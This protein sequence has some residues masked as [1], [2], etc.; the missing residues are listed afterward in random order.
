MEDSK[1]KLINNCEINFVIIVTALQ[2]RNTFLNYEELLP[3]VRNINIWYMF[4]TK[5]GY[6]YHTRHFYIKGNLFYI[7]ERENI[8]NKIY[9]SCTHIYIVKRAL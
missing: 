4:G 8:M 1:Y 2:K 6:T 5:Y 7:E 3:L 9:I